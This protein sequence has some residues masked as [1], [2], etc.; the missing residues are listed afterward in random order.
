MMQMNFNSRNVQNPV[1]RVA[2][3]AIV[4]AIVALLLLLV[5]SVAGVALVVGGV[6]ALGFGIRRL[7]LGGKWK[8]RKQEVIQEAE[9][10]ESVQKTTH[11]GG[12][13]L[14]Q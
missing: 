13:Q 5:I 3:G 2:I 4:I 8:R 12:R 14:P 1:A 6:L 10:I 11:T 7:L 9:V